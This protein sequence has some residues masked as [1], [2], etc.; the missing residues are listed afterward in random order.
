MNKIKSLILFTLITVLFISASPHANAGVSPVGFSLVHKVELPPSDFSVTGLRLSALW[1]IHRKVYGFDF[2][3]LGNIT[4]QQFVGT[5]VSGGFNLNQGQ[6]HIVGLQA[7]GVANI[8]NNNARILGLQVAGLLNSNKAESRVLGLQIAAIANISPHTD[9]YGAQI[10]LYNRAHDVYGFQIGL[11][12]MAD[13]LHGIQIGLLNFNVRGLF[14]V[15][16]I[17]NIGF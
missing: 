2:G 3:G 9:V 12:N 11:I 17:L 15:S 16:P 7:A 10:G 1:G 5:A 8:N 4:E 13:S 14:A 6:T